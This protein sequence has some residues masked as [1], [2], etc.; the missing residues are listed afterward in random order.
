MGE[1]QVGKYSLLPRPNVI[2]SGS[3]SGLYH[4]V[5][6]SAKMYAGIQLRHTHSL[7]STAGFNTSRPHA[8]WN[9]RLGDLFRN[10]SRVIIAVRARSG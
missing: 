5:F 3:P 4:T 1:V 8:F 7:T 9:D 10:L 2:Q 6:Q